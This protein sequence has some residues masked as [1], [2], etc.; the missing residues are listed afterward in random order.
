[1]RAGEGAG[2]GPGEGGRRVSRSDYVQRRPFSFPSFLFSAHLFLFYPFSC[3]S[4]LSRPLPFRVFKRTF[5]AYRVQ[6]DEGAFVSFVEGLVLGVVQRQ[7]RHQPASFVQVELPQLV[8]ARQF[9]VDEQ[10]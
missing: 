7:L 10:V 2:R 4:S 6:K 5:S 9:W 1:M 3:P 8:A